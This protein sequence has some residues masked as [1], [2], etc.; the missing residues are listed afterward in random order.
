VSPS[1]ARPDQYHFGGTRPCRTQCPLRGHRRT[2][3]IQNRTFAHPQ[4]RTN[5]VHAIRRPK[6]WSCLAAHAARKHEISRQL[7]GFGP[8][9]LP[10]A[11]IFRIRVKPIREKYS[12][13]VFQKYMLLSRRPA[14]ARGA[15]ASS[16]T[17]K[18]DAMDAAASVRRMML[19]ADG[20][21]VWS[22]SPDAG[23]KPCRRKPAR[24][25]WL[26]SPVHRGERV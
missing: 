24:R 13:S 6:S 9:D 8:S 5:H 18:R 25:R 2:W 23:I 15:Y 16:R 4:G 14:S 21:V 19:A 17:W 26:K 22:W 7:D 12:S 11:L 10:D 1:I 20:K 3:R